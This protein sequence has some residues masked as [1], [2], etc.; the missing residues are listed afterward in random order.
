MKKTRYA[1]T[2]T[3]KEMVGSIIIDQLFYT[4]RRI[5]D[6]LEG[7]TSTYRRRVKAAIEKEIVRIADK[8]KFDLGFTLP[9][10]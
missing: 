4:A 10:K 7:D 3:P 9:I 6:E 8:Y 1:D 2:H 5:D